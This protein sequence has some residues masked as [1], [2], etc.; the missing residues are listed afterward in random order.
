MLPKFIILLFILSASPVMAQQNVAPDTTK[1][2]S[3][4]TLQTSTSHVQEIQKPQVDWDKRMPWIIASGMFLIALAG[5]VFGLYRFQKRRKVAREDAFEDEQGKHDF[6]DQQK[7]EKAKGQAGQYKAFLKDELGTIGILG[8]SQVS[9]LQV[10]VL[11][12]FISLDLSEDVHTEEKY[13]RNSQNVSYCRQNNLSPEDVVRRAFSKF[14]MLLILGDPGSGKTTLLKYFAVSCIEGEYKKFGFKREPLTMFLPMRE[15]DFKDKQPELCEALEK[16]TRIP[17]LT[18]E[19][20]ENWLAK[21]ETIL[22]LD[23]LDE[24]AD[25]KKRRQACKWIDETA[26]RMTKTKFIVTSRWTGIDN[27]KNIKITFPNIRAD[28]QDLSDDQKK[29]FLNKWFEVAAIAGKIAPK[30]NDPQ[31]WEQKEKER[32]KEQAGYV[33][34]YLF[35]PQ[36]KILKELASTP[37]IL[38]IIALLHREKKYLAPSRTKLYSAAMHYMLEERDVEKEI[39]TPLNANDSM[40]VLK[41]TAMWMQEDLKSDEADAKKFQDFLQE[42]LKDYHKDAREFCTFLVKRAGLLIDYD[43]AYYIFRHKSFR[44]YFVGERIAD[45]WQDRKFLR[46]MASHLGEEWWKEPLRF[47]ISSSDGEKFDAFIDA[48]FSGSKELVQKEQNFLQQLIQEAPAKRIKKLR[49]KLLD[50]RIK[51]QTKLYI[52]ESLKKIG[53]EEAVK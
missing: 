15:I 33:I 17:A 52:I 29:S 43:K 42:L 21:E 28:V 49:E 18:K 1:T 46:R 37:M 22:L 5:L 20:F 40:A 7:E 2:D 41:P 14:R 45:K 47:F 6:K 32:A 23:G 24:I 38:Q 4:H 30:G 36:N 3:L 19:T 48:F 27:E 25:E 44:E 9:A 16:Y 39:P 13:R 51:S 10:N 11:E 12:T 50:G 34:K 31:M 35:D 53:S 8:S 26:T